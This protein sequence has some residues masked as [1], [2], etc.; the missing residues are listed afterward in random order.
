MKHINYVNMNKTNL[1]RKAIVNIDMY[2][3]H[4]K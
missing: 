4:K 1:V 2:I 3:F